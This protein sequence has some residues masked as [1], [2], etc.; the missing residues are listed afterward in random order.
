MSAADGG[1]VGA[2]PGVNYHFH[3]EA[4][5]DGEGPLGAHCDAAEA[6][7]LSVVCVT[8]HVERL[9]PTGRWVVEPEEVRERFTRQAEAVAAEDAERDELD[10]RLGAEF[11]YRPEWRDDLEELA[12]AVPF[13][14]VLGS[15]HVVDGLNVSG[16]PEVDDYFGGRSLEEAYGAYFDTL[17]EMVAWGAFDA[18]AHFDVVKRYGHEHYG[19][20]DPR[21]FEEPIRE[22]L[23]AMADG[24]VGIEVNASGL[25]QAPAAPYPAARVLRWAR[26]QGVPFL[27]AGTDSHRPADLATG[28]GGA[29]EAARRAGWREVAVIGQRRVT[30]G[31]PLG[32]G[33]RPAA[34][35]RARGGGDR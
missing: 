28:L 34:G 3:D 32:P 26:E 18:V 4:S 14:F 21:R 12:A 15:V 8:N 25:A 22:V 29:A 35:G 23:D 33:N 20:Y 27:T 11:E 19:P 13:D 9:T 6:A 17:R 1:P 2:A 30:D 31:R 7:G 24:G 16:G 10:V 5:S